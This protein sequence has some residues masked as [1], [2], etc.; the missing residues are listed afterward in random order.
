MS[1]IAPQRTSDRIDYIR[2]SMPVST[3]YQFAFP[4]YPALQMDELR[5]AVGRGFYGYNRSLVARHGVVLLW[6]DTRQEM[7]VCCQ[8]S[9]QAL[10]AMRLETLPA[11]GIIAWAL[12]EGAHFKRIDYAIDLVGEHFISTNDVLKAVSNGKMRW[13]GKEW[14]IYAKT[15]KN[16]LVANDKGSTVVLGARDAP[17]FVRI[18]DKAAEQKILGVS[19]TR[20]EIEIK[21][22]RCQQ[23]ASDIA[24]GDWIEAGRSHLFDYMSAVGKKSKLAKWWEA[25]QSMTGFAAVEQIARTDSKP[26]NFVESIVLPFLRN[27]SQMLS[28]ENLFAMRTIINGEL[29]ARNNDDAGL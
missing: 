8:I 17:R 26:N 5:A 29:F 14:G 13:K 23:L 1:L 22:Q 9:G 7:G 20:L 18:Y 21:K 12:N 25:L 16:S 11:E 2:Y 28:D 27:R 15:A 4:F 6:H 10:A 19:W 24:S 3:G